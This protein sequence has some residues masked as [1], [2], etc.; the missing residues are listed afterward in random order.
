M[1]YHNTHRNG[2]EFWDKTYAEG[3]VYGT[4]P[5]QAVQKAL[6]V[7]QQTGRLAPNCCFVE[8]GCGYGRDLSY[9][10]DRLAL[11]SCIGIDLSRT[12]IELGRRVNSCQTHKISFIEDDAIDAL[13]RFDWNIGKPVYIYTHYFL[14][15]FDTQTRK[16]LVGMAMHRCPPGGLLILSEY[17]ANDSRFGQGDEVEPGTFVLYPEKP[18]H[19]IHFF[20]EEEISTLSTCP[21][22]KLIYKCEYDEVEM[23][24]GSV[25]HATSWLVIFGKGREE[26]HYDYL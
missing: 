21:N 5:S 25:L 8:L 22:G 15:L 4:R 26:I 2:Q 12:A 6:E 9:V 7:L 24:R 13:A 19:K 1:N 16:K 3:F 18:L 23:I 10:S 11:S 20:T 17:S 14:Q